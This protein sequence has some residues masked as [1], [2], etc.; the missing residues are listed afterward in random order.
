MRH[1]ALALFVCTSAAFAPNSVHAIPPWAR[2]YSMSCAGC[3]QPVVPRLNA[4]GLTFKWAGY[5]MPNE[6]GDKM[7]VKK[8]EEY[9]AARAIV[10]YNFEKTQRANADV[11]ALDVPSASL[12]AAG[13]VGK[14][15]GA[16]I[17]FE[18][19]SDSR[20]DLIAQLSAV[21]GKENGF[22]G[23]RVGMGHLIVGGA[24]AG[25]DRPTGIL[26]PLALERPLTSSG[27]P[28]SF[29]G[30]LAGAEAYYVAGSR[31]RTSIQ[32]V[33]GAPQITRGDSPRSARPTTDF[34][35]S[36][37]LIWDAAGSGLSM[38]AY[39]GAITGLD[40]SNANGSSRYVRL[41][42]SANKF[43]GPFE[44]VGGYAYSRDSNVPFGDASGV[45][46]SSPS[47]NAYW[48]T[49]QYTVPVSSLT[50]FGRFESLDPNRA[51]ADDAIRRVV[52]GGVLPLNAPAYVRLALEYFRE[53]PQL[54]GSARR[55]G[56]A[57]EAQ[58]AF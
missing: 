11:N 18:R 27:I 3:H 5:R 55:N 42:A 52:F 33:N 53:L 35:L 49:G 25:F 57:L 51:I 38:V 19:T 26:S 1:R 23:V 47:G 10:R 9:L 58:I 4:T 13:P 31:N 36:N 29:A 7:E 24:V 30:D 44:I 22:G 41:A 37:Q 43:I 20:V 14:Y 12:F 54:S 32:V 56:L 46:T 50:V 2:K 28:F 34:V 39:F 45:A 17:E 8:I 15:Y 40:S 48:F 16:F 6:L 21:W